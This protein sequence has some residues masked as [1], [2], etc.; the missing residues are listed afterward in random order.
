MLYVDLRIAMTKFIKS[1]WMCCTIP[2]KIA[3]NFC[4]M[5]HFSKSGGAKSQIA[6]GLFKKGETKLYGASLWVMPPAGVPKRYGLKQNEM[7][8]LS[9]LAIYPDVP[10][11]G[12]S[13]VI[14]YGIR[15]IKKYKSQIQMLITWADE[16]QKHTGQIYKASNWIFDGMTQPRHSW[17]NKN[18]RLVSCYS[19]GKSV[20]VKIMDEKYTRIGP[21]RKHRYIYPLRC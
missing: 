5:H 21:F 9:R 3:E 1:E 20:P 10:T 19:H 6:I 4:K 11:N 15:H 7:Y 17:V 2:H 14:G 13:F 16:Y 8:C 12:A 18:G